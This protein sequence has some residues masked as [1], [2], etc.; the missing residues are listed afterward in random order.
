ML[1]Q[2]QRQLFD[3]IESRIRT[4]GAPPSYRDMASKM[5][6]V[7]LNGIH[8]MVDRLVERGHVV[9][10][11]DKR[12]SVNIVGSVRHFVWDDDTKRLVPFVQGRTVNASTVSRE[13]KQP[14]PREVIL[15]IRSAAAKKGRATRR[16]MVHARVAPVAAVGAVIGP[17]GAR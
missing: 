16:N 17:K 13:T 2:R 4:H 14:K 5:G 6:C 7:G 3:F 1:T 11:R 15:A 10:D 8:Q 12:R 9:R